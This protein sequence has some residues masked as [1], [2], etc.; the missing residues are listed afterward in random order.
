MAF[1]SGAPGT[2]VELTDDR[3]NAIGE[4]AGRPAEL[5]QS[6]L[7]PPGNTG[8][9]FVSSHAVSVGG[10]VLF[11]YSTRRCVDVDPPRKS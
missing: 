6:C 9:L 10:E 7:T 8:C 11:W 3:G 2:R 5:T 1:L 4:L